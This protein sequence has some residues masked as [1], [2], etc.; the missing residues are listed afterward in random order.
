MLKNEFKV[1]VV[2]KTQNAYGTVSSS[3]YEL[4]ESSLGKSLYLSS[5]DPKHPQFS[6][7]CLNIEKV[8]SKGFNG[9]AFVMDKLVKLRFN[10]SDL[11]LIPKS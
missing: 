7:H 11:I 10:F 8:G 9:Y 5:F 4:S 1:G 6:N 3:C 2:F